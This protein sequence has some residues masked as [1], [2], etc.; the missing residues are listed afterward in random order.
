[1]NLELD[2]FQF[3][4]LLIAI[5]LVVYNMIKGIFGTKN[6]KLNEFLKSLDVEEEEVIVE[7]VKPLPKKKPPPSAHVP[8]KPTQQKFKKIV[9]YKP[10]NFYAISLSTPPSRASKLIVKTPL[11][12]QIITQTILN[13]PPGAWW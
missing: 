2:P 11:R 5:V 6:E 13:K 9:E 1:M 4:G 7:R 10:D 8:Y 12:D 3:L